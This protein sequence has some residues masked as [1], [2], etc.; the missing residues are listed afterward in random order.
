[1][2]VLQF[3]WYAFSFR[4]LLYKVMLQSLAIYNCWLCLG[5]FSCTSVIIATESRERSRAWRALSSLQ[6]APAGHGGWGRRLRPQTDMGSC[7]NPTTDQLWNCGKCEYGMVVTCPC[8]CPGYL[9]LTP[10]SGC[11]LAVCAL[12]NC[13]ASPRVNFLS[14][15][16]GLTIIV[17]TTWSCGEEGLSTWQKHVN[18]YS[19]PTVPDQRGGR[20]LWLLKPQKATKLCCANDETNHNSIGL[21]CVCVR[22]RENCKL[23]RVVVPTRLWEAACGDAPHDYV[24]VAPE[25]DRPSG[26]SRP[27]N[28]CTL[29]VRASW[30]QRRIPCNQPVS[31]ALGNSLESGGRWD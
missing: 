3:S 29:G 8:F 18:C 13:I 17:S 15:R 19:F 14:C 24:Q 2:T 1:M 27:S 21:V 22:E 5:N 7:S 12:S 26:V 23:S 9:G 28:I 16:I 11:C 30:F 31:P 6:H 4:F 20:V 25:V 10:N